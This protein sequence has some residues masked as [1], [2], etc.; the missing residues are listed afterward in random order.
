MICVSHDI[1]PL[2]QRIIHVLRL[3]SKCKHLLNKEHSYISCHV[4]C[5][6]CFDYSISE[7]NIPSRYTSICQSMI[8]F[9]VCIVNAFI[10][11]VKVE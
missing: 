3:D 7:S 10:I 4:G 9:Q 8:L 11:F 5:L 2:G 6:M 1:V